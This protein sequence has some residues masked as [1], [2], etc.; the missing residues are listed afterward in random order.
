MVY[1]PVKTFPVQGKRGPGDVSGTTKV[2]CS[3]C[4]ID[5]HIKNGMKSVCPLCDS[6]EVVDSLRVQIGN[7]AQELEMTKK[8]LVRAQSES[9]AMQTMR[10]AISIADIEDVA[11]IK[12]IAYRWRS[13]PDQIVVLGSKAK[14]R[15]GI[16]IRRRDG[17]D[18]EFFYPMSVG[19][20]AFVAA[21]HDLV[22]ARGAERAMDGYAQAVA[23]KLV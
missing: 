4:R 12:G 13:D 16:E 5:Y 21:Y 7:L 20:V 19:G 1:D 8:D 23:E 15:V 17:G 6:L 9:D 2:S 18:S 10:S 11:E 22:K 14:K 3:S